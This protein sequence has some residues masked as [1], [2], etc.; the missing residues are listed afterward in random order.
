M[1]SINKKIFFALI[2][3]LLWILY[4]SLFTYSKHADELI[5][6][7][8]KKLYNIA[9]SVPY[10]FS[11]NLNNP[12]TKR[13]KETNNLLKKLDVKNVSI[14]IKKQNKYYYKSS[15]STENRFQIYKGNTSYLDNVYL[16]KSQNFQTTKDTKTILLPIIEQG[17]I[18]YV[19]SVKISVKKLMQEIDNIFFDNI[20]YFIISLL[21][22]LPFIVASNLQKKLLKDALNITK[23]E[24]KSANNKLIEHKNTLESIVQKRTKEL[25]KANLKLKELALIDTLTKIPN[26]RA[27]DERLSIEVNRAKRD[28]TNLAQL[29]LDIDFF[30]SYNDNYGHDKGD[31]TLCEVAKAI[32][33]SLPRDIDFAARYGGEEFVVLLPDTDA[34][35][36]Y[37]VAKRIQNNVEE[38]KIKHDFAQKMDI[39]TVSVGCTALKGEQVNA[40]DLLKQSDIALYVSKNEGKNRTEIFEDKLFEHYNH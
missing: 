2:V 24:V 32:S 30:K 6:S 35:G 14:F 38:L 15:S 29:F 10:L 13:E 34:Q 26:R 25:E 8:D 17:K 11:D 40:N 33:E 31:V 36:A 23:D 18:S 9:V 37:K 5:Q 3:Y 21:F 1:L 27:Y 28:N 19:V 4:N 7:F 12:K 39:L 20:I 22:A 16:K